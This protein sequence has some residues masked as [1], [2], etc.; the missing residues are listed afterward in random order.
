MSNKLHRMNEA[1]R[2]G[3]ARRVLKLF[4]EGYARRQIART[5]NM[6]YSEVCLLIRQVHGKHHKTRQGTARAP[7]ASYT[8]WSAR[9]ARVL[10]RTHRERDQEQ[11]TL[12]EA[13]ARHAKD[14]KNLIAH[15][16]R[17]DAGFT[18]EPPEGSEPV[19]EPVPPPVEQG[20]LW[21][22]LSPEQVVSMV[23]EA[24][25]PVVLYYGNLRITIEPVEERDGEG[26]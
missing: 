10:E 25:K 17:L 18:L 3:F 7:A 12:G 11:I 2:R 5:L 8:L 16:W 21:P 4:E 9:R 13:Q 15:Y 20:T 6:S 24:G 23:V 1:M 26:K 22:A 14:G 19:E